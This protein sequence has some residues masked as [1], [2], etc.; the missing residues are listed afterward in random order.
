V[1]EEVL[2]LNA[3]LEKGGEF[4]PKT[5]LM[6]DMA[7]MFFDAGFINARARKLLGRANVNFPQ[8][9][10]ILAEMADIQDYRVYFYDAPPYKWPEDILSEEEK[11]RQREAQSKKD[12]FFRRLEIT[13][14]FIVRRGKLRPASHSRYT[15]EDLR[16]DLEQVL[17]EEGIYTPELM[18][19]LSDRIIK[20]MRDR[21]ALQQKGVDSRLV[22]D[23]VSLCALE[24]ITTAVLVSNDSDFAPALKFAVATGVRTVVCGPKSDSEEYR[25][26][27]R[28]AD[29]YIPLTKDLLERAKMPP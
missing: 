8:L 10:A 3:I 26:L 20:T 24:K 18:K 17:R 28:Y 16:G 1:G 27:I 13:D 19:R 12:R 21:M 7:A 9:A 14:R 29:I 5:K 15:Y 11:K 23:L 22:T 25:P 4:L 2:R 6:R